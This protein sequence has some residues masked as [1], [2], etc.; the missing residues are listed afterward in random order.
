MCRRVL[1]GIAVVMII[2]VGTTVP[3]AARAIPPGRP[4]GEHVSHCAQTMGFSGHHNPGRHRGIT[5]WDQEA[6]GA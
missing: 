1:L 5:G 3:A 4:F 6:C 2:L